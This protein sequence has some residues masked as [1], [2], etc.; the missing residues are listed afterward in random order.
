[1]DNIYLKKH[2]GASEIF[3]PLLVV[4]GVSNVGFGEL[5]EI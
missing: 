3:G 2:I 4:D 5:V 1:M